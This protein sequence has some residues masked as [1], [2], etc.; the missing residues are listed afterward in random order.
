MKR[1]AD[2]S[3]DILK[4][5]EEHAPPQGGLEN[6]ISIPGYDQPTILAHTELLIEGGYVDGKVLYAL[7]GPIQAMVNKLTNHGHDALQAVDSDTTWNTVKKTALEKGVSLTLEWGCSSGDANCASTP[8]DSLTPQSLSP[9]PATSPSPQYRPAP[10]GKPKLYGFPVK[11]IQLA[12][13]LPRSRR[14]PELKRKPRKKPLESFTITSL[15][16]CRRLPGER[17]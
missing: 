1:D 13:A 4:Y 17:V 3:R 2:L 11:E 6:P 8:A 15:I 14:W 12:R 7:T 5:I 16:P 10:H 9:T